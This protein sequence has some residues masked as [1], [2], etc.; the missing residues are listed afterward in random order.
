MEGEQHFPHWFL[1]GS[2]HQGWEEEAK[3]AACANWAGPEEERVLAPAVGPGCG[4]LEP[5]A[6]GCLL[7][8]PSALKTR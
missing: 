7:T 3:A 4:R 8:Y 5:V 2:G 6:T 1:R